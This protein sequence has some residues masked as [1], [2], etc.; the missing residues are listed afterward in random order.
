MKTLIH[1]MRM[2]AFMTFLTGIV[3]PLLVT[4]IGTGLYPHQA[5]GSLIGNGEFILGST[6]VAQGFESPRYFWP[7]P[8]GG[9]H[10][11]PLP[12]GGTNLGPTGAELKKNVDDQRTRL[13]AANPPMGEPP[14][15]LL[16]SSGSGLDPEISP[17]AALYQVPRVARA[18]AMDENLVNDLVQKF[19]KGRQLGLLGEPRVNVLALN[20]ALDEAQG[21]WIKPVPKPK[22][23]Q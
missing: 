19:S 8:S 11:N 14:Q 6:L 23:V 4:V 10:Y 9:A 1:S 18:R 17:Q 12:S 5:E 7:R 15:E 20:I 3:Y 2:L 22:E 16:F 21:I 13:K